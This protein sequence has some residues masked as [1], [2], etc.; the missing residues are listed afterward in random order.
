M[1]DHALKNIKTNI[2]DLSHLSSKMFFFLNSHRNI[3][4]PVGTISFPIGYI[5]F[6][7]GFKPDFII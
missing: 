5:Q 3:I 7:T 4:T 6:Q 2:I 1:I